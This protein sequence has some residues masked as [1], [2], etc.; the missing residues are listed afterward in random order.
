MDKTRNG[1]QKIDQVNG[2]VRKRR[3]RIPDKPDIQISLW[4]MIKSFIGKDLTRV[5]LPVNFN[6]PISMLQK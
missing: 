3:A 6:E 1:Q 4:G 5:A 2:N